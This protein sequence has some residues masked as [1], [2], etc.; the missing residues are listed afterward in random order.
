MTF[1]S[2]NPFI[3]AIVIIN[4]IYCMNI[5]PTRFIFFFK[6]ARGT[7]ITILNLFHWQMWQESNLLARV[8]EAPPSP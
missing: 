4:F 5:A 2:M 8:L 6:I 3:I 1:A 7:T